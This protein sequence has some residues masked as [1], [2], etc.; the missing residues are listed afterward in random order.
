MKPYIAQR[1]FDSKWYCWR[2]FNTYSEAERF[3]STAVQDCEW[4]SYDVVRIVATSD[5]RVL[6]GPF[7][8]AELRGA[9]A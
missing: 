7:T 6:L 2:E 8:D 1:L 9:V 3:I 5:M 4:R